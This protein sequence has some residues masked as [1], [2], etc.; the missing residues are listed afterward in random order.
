MYLQT[1][2][3]HAIVI[4][5][6]SSSYSWNASNFPASGYT[7]NMTWLGV[8]PNITSSSYTLSGFKI[9]D[10]LPISYV[11]ILSASA[12]TGTFTLVLDSNSSIIY[13]AFSIIL[14]SQ[15]NSGIVYM[16]RV[17]IIHPIQSTSTPSSINWFGIIHNRNS[18]SA[19][20]HSF[21]FPIPVTI[22]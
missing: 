2:L 13:A 4:G 10:N 22:L 16:K 8:Y 14:L 3:D 20:L 19:L 11:A 9:N 18:T 6:N 17:R 12:I 1:H 7:Y 15:C 21:V 5:S